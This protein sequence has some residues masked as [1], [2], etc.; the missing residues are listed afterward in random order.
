MKAVLFDTETTG[1]IDNSGRPLDKQPH[2]IEFSAVLIDHEFE[3]IE[4]LDF[5]I[6]PGVKISKEITEI[7]H[8]TNE[9]LIGKPKFQDR[10]D[11]IRALFGK[12]DIVVAHNLSYDMSMINFELQ[13]LGVGIRWPEIKICTVE[14]TEYLKGHRLSLAALHELLF[15]ETFSNAHRAANDVA[16]LTRC[17]VELVKR[18]IC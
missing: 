7:T 15:N 10:L 18:G 14:K 6:N 2:V 16:A 5:L 11:E 4:K 8:I 17:Y 13:R 3:V 9:D 1:L 12:A